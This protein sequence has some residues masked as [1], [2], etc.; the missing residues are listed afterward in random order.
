MRISRIYRLLRLITLLQ[1]GRRYTPAELARELEVSRRTIFRDLNILEMAKIPY[2]FDPEQSSYRINSH[3]FLPPINLD[4]AEA[5]SILVL[6]RRLRGS[7]KVP[8]LSQASRAAMKIE[9]VL[10]SYVR[11][12]VGS[13]LEH[14]AVHLGP[15]A[16]GDAQQSEEVFEDLVS[17]IAKKNICRMT[18]RS[19]T[20]EDRIELRLHPYRLM[21][22]QRGWYVIGHSEMHREVRTF[23]LNRIENLSVSTARFENGEDFDPDEHFGLAWSMIPEGKEYDIHLHFSSKVAGNVAE[24]IWHPTQQINQ[25]EDGSIEFT[26]RVDGLGEISWWI[27]GYGDQVE[28][29]EPRQLRDRIQQ[30][31]QRMV[32]IY[33]TGKSEAEA[34][35]SDS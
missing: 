24:V 13:V 16:A 1:S 7:S 26:C 19:F 33:Q 29:R 22:F 6:A 34:G 11:N 5:L 27:L 28:V 14:M 21:F 20:E 8:L 2:F 23:K 9:G 10:P 17:A 31:A 32:R 15:P 12:H 18:Y 4:L 3:F 25:N 30:T 35:P